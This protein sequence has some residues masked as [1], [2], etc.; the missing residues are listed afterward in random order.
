MGYVEA[1]EKYNPS[2]IDLPIEVLW[3]AESPPVAGGYFYFEKPSARGHFFGETMK[4]LGWWDETGSTQSGLDKKPFLREI[5]RT[6]ILSHR[7]LR[8]SCEWSLQE[9]KEEGAS[10]QPS[11]A[12]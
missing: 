2:R 9:R 10:G 3:I 11:R 6:R 5:S 8:Q 12:S 7:P 4:A 1:R